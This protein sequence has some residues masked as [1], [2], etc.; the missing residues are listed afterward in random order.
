MRIHEAA[1]HH[2]SCERVVEVGGVVHFEQ[3][4]IRLRIAQ[5][6][7]A[8][9]VLCNAEF[10]GDDAVA[11]HREGLASECDRLP[12][13][14]D[15]E[16]FPFLQ[17]VLHRLPVH[18]KEVGIRFP[19]H[20][21]VGD[22]SALP[23]DDR[24]AG[25]IAHFKAL[26]GKII[27]RDH[28]Q[29]E[30]ILCDEIAVSDLICDRDHAG[31]G[32]IE[33]I[34]PR[35]HFRTV[36]ED[37]LGD[38]VLRRTHVRVAV[39][40]LH[41]LDIAV[42]IDRRFAYRD[43]GVC[44]LR[45]EAQHGK[46]IGIF[47]IDIVLL[48]RLRDRIASE[49]ERPLIITD[50][51]RKRLLLGHARAH[52]VHRDCAEG[53]ARSVIY[54][55]DIQLFAHVGIVE[56]NILPDH[57]LGEFGVLKM[58]ARGDGRD[59]VARLFLAHVLRQADGDIDLTLRG[60]AQ[61]QAD[62]A[63]SA[64]RKG[65]GAKLAAQVLPRLI[66]VEEFFALSVKG[67]RPPEGLVGRADIGVEERR[68]GKHLPVE[69]SFFKVAVLDRDRIGRIVVESGHA[70][71][72]KF[73]RTLRLRRR[74]F[75]LRLVHDEVVEDHIGIVA[76]P[77]VV[78]IGDADTDILT[79]MLGE[80][81]DVAH[82]LIGDEWL[83][84]RRVRHAGKHRIAARLQKLD[85]ALFAVLRRAEQ[86]ADLARAAQRE[87]IACERAREGGIPALQSVIEVLADLPD[88]DI[89]V[90]GSRA[91]DN[92][93]SA[94]R[95]SVLCPAREATHGVLKSAVDNVVV[96][97]GLLLRTARCK[98]DRH[99]GGKCSAQSQNKKFLFHGFLR[100]IFSF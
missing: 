15:E 55:L 89:A 72:G 73:V 64:Q 53:A 91:V 79:E 68:A 1:Q 45:G 86:E 21:V 38:G 54:D 18:V 44:R 59:L 58:L 78:V 27:F 85:V 8:D 23:V 17:V 87:H 22:G 60:A 57:V 24:P 51:E 81:D 50:H 75:L 49:A 20:F 39:G 61:E 47:I 98:A 74:D 95:V 99:R 69:Q 5:R 40:G 77:A 52:V 32:D 35:R 11:R 26:I 90:V 3:L 34:E 7:I 25:E 56:L 43:I 29:E 97:D 83:G 84:K 62:D 4:L 76:V 80:I 41:A 92:A 13:I 88:F 30:G 100:I 46:R 48:R 67:A 36:G 19:E 70:D 6:H 96:D 28:L 9:R 33:R 2:L 94:E 66:A 16:V 31:P 63:V 65:R 12:L 93:R 71:R 37:C 14:R 42:Q 10:E 82:H